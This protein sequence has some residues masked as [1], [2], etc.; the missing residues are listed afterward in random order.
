MSYLNSNGILGLLGIYKG[1]LVTDLMNFC[2]PLE[3]EKG[4]FP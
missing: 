4:S 2:N 1:L 3:V